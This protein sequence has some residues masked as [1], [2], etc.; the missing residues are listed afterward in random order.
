MIKL[1]TAKTLGSLIA[2]RNRAV[3]AFLAQTGQRESVLAGITWE[4][5][6]RG[7]RIALGHRDR[8]HAVIEIGPEFPKN[9]LRQRYRFVIG[10][11]ALKL[12]EKLPRPHVG[13]VFKTAK[14]KDKMAVRTIARIVDEAADT[15][16]IQYETE[17]TF[18]GWMWH[19]VHPHVFRRY[20]KRQMKL[21]G[22][23]DKDLLEYMLGHRVTAYDAWTDADLLSNYKMA[24]RKLAVL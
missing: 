3:I 13:R 9:K 1:T 23:N 18:R 7:K 11:N 5:I 12:M 8:S 17:R 10:S 21:G 14:G 2:R 15:C 16:E 4:M 19:G 20:W 22:V 6:Q 24:E